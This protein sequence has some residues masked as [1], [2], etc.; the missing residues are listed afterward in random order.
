MRQAVG[1][2]AK[3]VGAGFRTREGVECDVYLCCRCRRRR[4][5]RCVVGLGNDLT[6]HLAHCWAP[7]AGRMMDHG[8]Q[9]SRPSRAGVAVSQHNSPH[10]CSERKGMV[11]MCVP[12]LCSKS[13]GQALSGRPRLLGGGLGEARCPGNIARPRLA[14]EV[15]CATNTNGKAY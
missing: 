10:S 14:A 2:R 12:A 11:C 13:I 5:R 8:T 9:T 15:W 4:R 6:T 7:L 1:S 3:V